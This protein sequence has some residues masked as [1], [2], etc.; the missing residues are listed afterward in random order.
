MR[1]KL[2][3]L[4]LQSLIVFTNMACVS[5]LRVLIIEWTSMHN[6]VEHQ[7]L[8][9]AMELAVFKKIYQIIGFEKLWVV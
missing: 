3:S 1:T 9:H 8:K 4:K 5:S 6:K 7:N 2:I